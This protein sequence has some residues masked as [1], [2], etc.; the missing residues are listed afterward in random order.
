LELTKLL[1]HKKK[2]KVITWGLHILNA[3]CNMNRNG[4]FDGEIICCGGIWRKDPDILMGPQFVKFFDEIIIDKAFFGIVALNLEYGW[5]GTSLLEVEL[6]KKVLSI[7]EKV[8]GV[9]ISSNFEKVSIARIGPIDLLDYVITDNK[10]SPE[11]LD[12]YM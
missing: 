2:L 12:K 4:S 7:S 11:L 1:V 3:L 6:T 5:M 10:I 9:M 8:Y